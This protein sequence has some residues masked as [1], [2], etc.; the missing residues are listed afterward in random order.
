MEI[1]PMRIGAATAVTPEAL[2]RRE[3]ITF[4]N[5]L[6]VEQVRAPRLLESCR[7]RPDRIDADGESGA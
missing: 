2:T 3:F 4:D 5:I 6:P 7:N 1:T